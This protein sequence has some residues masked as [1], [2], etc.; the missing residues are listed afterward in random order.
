MREILGRR[1]MLPLLGG[2]AVIVV[3]GILL[4]AVASGGGGGT[5]TGTGPPAA[6]GGD[7][8][9]LKSPVVA[10]P[11]AT[12]VLNQPT[13]VATRAPNAAVPGTS[14]ADRLIITKFGVNA[15][16]TYK[17]VGPDGSMPNP[18]GPDDVAFYDFP[19]HPGLGGVPGGTGNVVLAGHVDS[20][21]AAC[22]NGTVPPPCTAVF[23]DI[24]GLKVGDELEV[25]VSGTSY[26]YRV[27]ANQSVDAV[28]ADFTKIVSATAQQTITLITC[29]GDFNTVTHEYNHRQVVTGVRI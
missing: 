10:S 20:G 29:G 11:E 21:R 24:G 8:A 12:L 15:P 22:K 17:V 2:L 26:K 7:F 13:V 16:L 9:G 25:S 3:I 5:N 6:A 28:T 4:V 18:N 14:N 1:G 23:W 19:N 27:T